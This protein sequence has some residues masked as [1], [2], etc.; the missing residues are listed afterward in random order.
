MLSIIEANNPCAVRPLGRAQW[1]GQ[2]GIIQIK[3]GKYA[4]FGDMP[5]GIRAALRNLHTYRTH[6]G[7]RSPRE[8][9]G[10]WAPPSDNNPT[11]AYVQFIARACGVHADDPLPLTCKMNK[12][13]ILAIMSFE[14]AGFQPRPR[15]LNAAFRMMAAEE[16]KAGRDP[17]PYSCGV[18]DTVMRQP[19]QRPKRTG[20]AVGLGGTLVAYLTGALDQVSSLVYRLPGGTLETIKTIIIENKLAIAG[21]LIALAIWLIWSEYN[22]QSRSPSPAAGGD[23]DDQHEPSIDRTDGWEGDNQLPRTR[24][25]GYSG[26]QLRGLI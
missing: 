22:E 3:G 4:R 10:R 7:L 18:V 26:D 12:R 17:S 2:T 5:H 20:G 23:N 1:N 15:D 16:A 14:G 24:D 13:L 25:A 9:I 8:I 21:A 11:S 19:A 6:H